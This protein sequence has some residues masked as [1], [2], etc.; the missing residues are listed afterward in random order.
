MARFNG[1]RGHFSRFS[2]SLTI[3]DPTSVPDAP[4][5][6]SVE[7]VANRA[8]GSPQAKIYFTPRPAD[9]KVTSYKVYDDTMTLLSSGTSS[10]ITVNLSETGELIFAMKAE[11]M[12]GLSSASSFVGG[13]IS[14]KPGVPN[15]SSAITAYESAIGIDFS[16]ITCNNGGL[17]ITSYKVEVVGVVTSTYSPS[18]SAEITGLTTGTEYTVKISAINDNGEGE[19][20]TTLVTPSAPAIFLKNGSF[21]T[22]IGFHQNNGTVYQG[23]L[24]KNNL[25]DT[26]IPDADFKTGAL[27]FGITYAAD[28]NIAVSAPLAY[29]A[30]LTSSPAKFKYSTNKGETWNDGSSSGLDSY[31]FYNTAYGNGVFVAVG[32]GPSLATTNVAALSIDGINWISIT[33][34]LVDNWSNIIFA[35][36]KFV[37]ITRT[38]GRVA[39]ST[40]GVTWST[41]YLPAA[42][43]GGWL[44]LKYLNNKFIITPSG[45]SS[46]YAYSNDAITWT[47]GSL[48][49]S[50]T[51]Y[52]SGGTPYSV[53]AP[54]VNTP[55][56]SNSSAIVSNMEY[57]N[58]MYFMMITF[59]NSIGTSGVLYAYFVSTDLQNWT[60]GYANMTGLV[61]NNSNGQVFTGAI[62]VIDDNKLYFLTW[63][64]VYS[65]TLLQTINLHEISLGEYYGNPYVAIGK[66]EKLEKQL[67]LPMY[68]GIGNSS[69]NK[70]AR[71]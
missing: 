35:Q 9:E 56:G 30:G 45:N 24:L 43:G 40:D 4:I 53:G 17:S 12:I 62:P 10:P 16:A 44:G 2:I 51:W 46:S 6:T 11:N 57:Y 49:T 5:I 55:L 63:A 31:N 25:S 8:Y 36:N 22:P 34:P 13:L 37:A 67:T 20:E 19:Y 69:H 3:P 26:S 52:D 14:T 64:P 71:M 47:V 58:G 32:R 1:R 21:M 59:S 61:P 54:L 68:T 41:E 23:I 42:P 39:I 28:K 33:L 66:E 48:P 18:G 60:A 65:G 15:S 50:F 29:F 27:N 38:S 70:G 7:N